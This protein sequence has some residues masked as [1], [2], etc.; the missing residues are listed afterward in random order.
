[1]LLLPENA[2]L[3]WT[4][5]IAAIAVLFAATWLIQRRQ[6]RTLESGRD[7]R[8]RQT[9]TVHIRPIWLDWPYPTAFLTLFFILGTALDAALP[10]RIL[11]TMVGIALGCLVDVLT[12]MPTTTSKA[13][14]YHNKRQMLEKAWKKR[15]ESQTP[16]RSPSPTM[17]GAGSPESRTNGTL[18]PRL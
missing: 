6:A 9:A 16:L 8:G 17:G 5:G 11:A 13:A 7:A 15:R 12:N 1:M 3:W 4:T 14:T 10:L 18:T 2:K